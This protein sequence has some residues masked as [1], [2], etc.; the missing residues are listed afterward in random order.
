LRGKENLSL[1]LSGCVSGEEN[2]PSLGNKATAVL[3]FL[4]CSTP[5]S[6]LRRRRRLHRRRR[7]RKSRIQKMIEERDGEKG[8][9]YPI[10][11]GALRVLF[12]D[13]K[14]K[15]TMKINSYLV[16]A[17]AGRFDDAH[18]SWFRS[19]VFLCFLKM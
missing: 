3:S 4:F 16:F 12:L 13:K 5:A 7:R 8:N 1:L 6:V 2:A 19:H 17:G 9:I 11:L 15:K 14:R 18:F 10:S